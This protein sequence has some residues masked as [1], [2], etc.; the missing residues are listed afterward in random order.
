MEDADKSDCKTNPYEGVDRYFRP[1]A[2]SVRFRFNHSSWRG[3]DSDLS[4]MAAAWCLLQSSERLLTVV[5]KEVSDGV[6]L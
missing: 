5:F 1:M 6:M 4:L 2:S 3:F